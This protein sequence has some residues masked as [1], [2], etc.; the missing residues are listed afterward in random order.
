MNELL[1]SQFIDDELDLDEKKD[2]VRAVRE[3]REYAEETLALLEQERWLRA[4]PE[5]DLPEMRFAA[6]FR[7]RL[8]RLLQPLGA[9]A[10]GAA[11]A[12]LVWFLMP[13]V[14]VGEI[15]RSHRFVLYQPEAAAV[16][17]SGSFTGWRSLPMKRAG[18]AGYWEITLELP[19]GEHRFG[20][21]VE[22]GRRLADP[23]VALREQDD[24]GGENSILEVALSS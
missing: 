19:P 8:L 20:Y 6:P 2:F 12:A 15:S 9:F 17:I 18:D 3:S 7:T 11:A 5:A 21:I 13:A 14:P 10:A 22:G 24:F 23:T 4:E 16:E 1:I